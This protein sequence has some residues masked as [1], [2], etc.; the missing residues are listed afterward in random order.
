V[1]Q[2]ARLRARNAEI[3]ARGGEA[4]D[5]PAGLVAQARGGCTWLCSFTLHFSLLSIVG[6]FLQLVAGDIT[7]RGIFDFVFLSFSHPMNAKK[8]KQNGPAAEPPRLEALLLSAQA[9]AQCAGLNE[10]A[11]QAWARLF[12]AEKFLKA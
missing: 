5:E 7:L 6:I 9:G 8:P 10:F 3:V 11:G 4:I 2:L 1:P 12:L